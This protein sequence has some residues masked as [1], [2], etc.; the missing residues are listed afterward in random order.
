MLTPSEA[1]SL[2]ST[3]PSKGSRGNAALAPGIRYTNITC[4]LA[5]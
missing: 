4:S 1:M 3:I 2:L 5:G